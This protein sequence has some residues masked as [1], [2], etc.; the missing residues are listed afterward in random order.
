[1]SRVVDIV[2]PVCCGI[3]VH[4]SF[5]V[6]CIATTDARNHT[7]HQIRRFSTFK[8]DLNKLADWLSANNC[9]DVCMEST[10]KYWIPVFNVLEKT[11]TVCLTHPKYVKAIKGKKTDKKDAKWISELFKCDLVR[12]SF[13]PPPLTRHLRELCRYYAKLTHMNSSEKNRGQNC[14]TVCNIKLDDVFSDVFGTSATRVLDKLIELGHSDFDV[15]PLLHKSCKASPEQVKDAINGELSPAQ[16]H[17]LA[18]VR[19]HMHQLEDLQNTLESFAT[20]LAF[21]YQTQIDL[22]MTVPGIGC[23][24]TAIRILAEIGVD[25]SVFETAKQLTSWAGLSPQNNESA[26][27]K[28]TT[29]IARAGAFLK[30]LLVQCTLAAVSSNKYPWLKNKYQSLKKRRGH[31]KAVIAIARKLLSAIWNMLAKNDPYNHELYLKSDPPPINR[32]LTAEQGLALLR[33]HGFQ[34]IESV[35]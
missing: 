25:M 3:D 15:A 30:P 4:K 5:L 16:S 8:G 27:K 19:Q 33:K 14:L 24:F 26:N 35:A 10:G 2:R 31:K 12:S 34:I 22:L 32:V 29:R 11:C 6:A 13:I 21:P 9:K 7:T 18:L 1:M 20:N 17:K 28:K 23:Q